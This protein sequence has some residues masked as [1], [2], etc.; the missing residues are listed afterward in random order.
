MPQLD[1]NTYLP[2]VVWLLIT[3]TALFLVMWRVAVPR[4]ADVLEARQKRIDD[5]LDKAADSQKEAEAA[6]EAYEA[7]LAEARADSQA[8][9]AKAADKIAA[10]AEE[11][12][13]ELSEEL[14]QKIA[15]SEAEIREAVAQAMES[16]PEVALQA[17]SAVIKR[18]TGEAAVKKEVAKA[19]DQALER[20]GE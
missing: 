3:F 6:L 8:L 17:A 16:I 12:N 15:A 5:N 4:I 14:D 10:E 11:R 2:Q 1:I 19:V 20:E 9:I 18:L 7:S 13:A